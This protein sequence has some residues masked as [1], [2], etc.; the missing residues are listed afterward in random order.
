M[1]YRS[2][3]PV[4]Q[5]PCFISCLKLKRHRSPQKTTTQKQITHTIRHVESKKTVAFDAATTLD[6]H[7][8]NV[9]APYNKNIYGRTN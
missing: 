8:I 7:K 5:Q 4:E 3:S 1:T 2:A 6:I 9:P